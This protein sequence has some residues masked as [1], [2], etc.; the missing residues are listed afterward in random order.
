MANGVPHRLVLVKDA[1]LVRR[2]PQWLK[3]WEEARSC[4]KILEAREAAGAPRFVLQ[5]GPPYANGSI[6]YGHVLNK[7]IKDRDHD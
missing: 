6:H 4:Q 7:V 1:D 5:D 2:E 3:R